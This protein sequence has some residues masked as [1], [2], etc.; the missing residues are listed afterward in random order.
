MKTKPSWKKGDLLAMPQDLQPRGSCVSDGC[1]VF[2]AEYDPVYVHNE[3]RYCEGDA[4]ELRPATAADLNRLI[5]IAETEKDRAEKRIDR[6]SDLYQL[7][8][9]NNKTNGV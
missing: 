1:A 9:M 6:L 4:K 7:F 5:G 8:F 3:W 2:V